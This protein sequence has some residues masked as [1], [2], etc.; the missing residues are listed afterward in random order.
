VGTASRPPER[1]ALDASRHHE[2]PTAGRRIVVIATTHGAPRAGLLAPGSPDHRAERFDSDGAGTSARHQDR[3]GGP[4]PTEPGLS[5]GRPPSP[6]PRG[7][8]GRGN[9]RHLAGVPRRVRPAGLPESRRKVREYPHFMHLQAA[10]TPSV[11]KSCRIAETSVAH[12]QVRRRVLRSRRTASSDEARSR[13]EPRTEGDRSASLWSSS[14][15][16]STTR[17]LRCGRW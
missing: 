7:E 17:S 16:E 1:G 2:G 13:A 5:A 6:E 9:G 10:L 4:G 3:Y 8:R 14:S 12:R 11:C 15:R